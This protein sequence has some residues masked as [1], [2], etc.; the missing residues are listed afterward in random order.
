MSQEGTSEASLIPSLQ[1]D[2]LAREI[3]MQLKDETSAVMA[4][5][6]RAA[7]EVVAQARS[8]ARKRMHEAIV[9]LRREGERRLAR[10]RAQ[11]ETETRAAEQRQAAYAVSAAMPLLTEALVERWR[12]PQ[13][14]KLWIEGVAELCRGRLRRGTWTVTHPAGWPAQE[15]KEFATAVAAGEGLK[16]GFEA[17]KGLVAGLIVSADQA[18]LDASPRGLLGDPHGIAG[19][20]LNEITREYER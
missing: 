11:I 5:A 9:E 18:V 7:R 8:A 6:K 2:A 19:M 16:V 10:G 17:G 1:S 15:Q 14:R 4:E 13:S 12:D 20:L 3:E